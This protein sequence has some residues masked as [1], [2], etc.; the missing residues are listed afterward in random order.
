MR[1]IDNQEYNHIHINRTVLHLCYLISSLLELFSLFMWSAL[2]FFLGELESRKMY[3][4]YN[5]D[6][7]V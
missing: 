1:E 2:D 5:T 7:P 6:H 4:A 3:I